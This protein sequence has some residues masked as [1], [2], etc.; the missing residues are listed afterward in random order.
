MTCFSMSYEI[1]IIVIYYG[2]NLSLYYS[3][4]FFEIYLGILRIGE[5][6]LSGPP[7][8]MCYTILRFKQV[9]ECRPT[10]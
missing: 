8:Y 2:L 4:E 1:K 10:K 7:G 5:A 9:I 3:Y 6:E